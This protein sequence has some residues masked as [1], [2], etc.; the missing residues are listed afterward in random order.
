MVL[1]SDEVTPITGTSL[2]SSCTP[3][4]FPSASSDRE[5]CSQGRQGGR[6]SQSYRYTKTPVPV[7]VARRV[8]VAVGSTAIDR[9]VVPRTSTLHSEVLVPSPPPHLREK[10]GYLFSLAFIG[11]FQTIIVGGVSEGGFI[12]IVS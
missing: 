5:E 7:R 6:D 3:D 12:E 10:N 4:K 9:I 8:V 11:I 1:F 2:D